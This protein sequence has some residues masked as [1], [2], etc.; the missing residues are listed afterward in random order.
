LDNIEKIIPRSALNGVF[1]HSVVGEGSSFARQRDPTKKEARY[2][3]GVVE[4][5]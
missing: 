1:T 2:A 4:I 3:Q 5:L